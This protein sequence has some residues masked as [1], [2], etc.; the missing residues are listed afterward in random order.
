ML[1]DHLSKKKM[2]QIVISFYIEAL[3]MFV[4]QIIYDLY[5]N[6]QEFLSS[7]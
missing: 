3:K 2:R 4:T 6:V 1:N 5:L 7:V